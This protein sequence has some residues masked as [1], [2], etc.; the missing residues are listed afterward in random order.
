MA[1]PNWYRKCV[2]CGKARH[3]NELLRIV[4]QKDNLLEIDFEQVKPGRGAYVCPRKECVM[5]AEKKYGLEKSY[6][7]D[8]NR[9]FYKQLIKQVE[10]IEH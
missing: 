5:L 4:K 3:K 9:S 1:Q 2:A 8:I 6:R 7:C 10:K